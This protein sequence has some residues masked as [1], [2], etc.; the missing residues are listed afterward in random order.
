MNMMYYEG[1]KNMENILITTEGIQRT[2]K[3][4]KPYDAICE[5]I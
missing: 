4:F 3:N 1:E 2:L 5:Y